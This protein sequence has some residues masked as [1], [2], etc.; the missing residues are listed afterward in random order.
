VSLAGERIACGAKLAASLIPADVERVAVSRPVEGLILVG[1]AKRRAAK[2]AM[3]LDRL[4][5]RVAL[6]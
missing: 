2:M 5:P 3:N 4:L 6:N 1:A